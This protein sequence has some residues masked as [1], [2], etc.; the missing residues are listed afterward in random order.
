MIGGKS[1]T[2]MIRG[3][4]LGVCLLTASL[5]FHHNFSRLCYAVFDITNTHHKNILKYGKGYVVRHHLQSGLIGFWPKWLA[6]QSVASDLQAH[7]DIFCGV[8]KGFASLLP[9]KK[10]LHNNLQ[11][12]YL[13]ASSFLSKLRDWWSLTN[14]LSQADKLIIYLVINLLEN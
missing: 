12:T 13:V 8:S 6:T 10:T 9:A 14:L 2:I 7:P 5:P 3:E 1:W 4:K 11:F